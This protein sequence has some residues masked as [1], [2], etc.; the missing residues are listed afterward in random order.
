MAIHECASTSTKYHYRQ[1]QEVDRAMSALR[2][3]GI[4]ITNPAMSGL[5]AIRGKLLA[6][7]GIKY[8]RV[9]SLLAKIIALSP[10]SIKLWHDVESGW[11]TEARR[12][13]GAP[14]VYRSVDDDVAA[15]LV[16]GEM[17]HELEESLMTPDEYIGE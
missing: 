1:L 3:R 15:M 12:K 13:P 14:P 16:R 10:G 4:P 17:T 5:S 11:M 6:Q 9:I 8:P 2:L 7:I